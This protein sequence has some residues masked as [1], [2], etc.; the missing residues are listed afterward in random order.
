MIALVGQAIGP[1]LAVIRCCHLL[2]FPRPAKQTK[3]GPGLPI[4][5]LAWLSC[6]F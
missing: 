2:H 1:N 4:V 6:V 5:D 3:Q